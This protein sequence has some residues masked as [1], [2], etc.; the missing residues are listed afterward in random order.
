MAVDE[1]LTAK[2][3]VWV[4]LSGTAAAGFGTDA[5]GDP[6]LAAVVIYSPTSDA[7]RSITLKGALER[8]SETDEHARIRQDE[9]PTPSQVRKAYSRM[10]LA[11]APRD[12]AAA[13]KMPAPALLA[14]IEA[15]T[16][17]GELARRSGEPP[18]EFYR[19]I[20][21]AHDALAQVTKR[22][23]AEIAR[24]AGVPAGT[25]ASW[26]HYARKRGC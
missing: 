6:A 24:R 7:L 13:L 4:P 8:L 11:D 1:C 2:P 22:P 26:V 21:R 15:A 3:S 17:P 16:A 12:G 18:E 10:V 9:P 20:A 19:R 14:E 23:T 5:L 25:A